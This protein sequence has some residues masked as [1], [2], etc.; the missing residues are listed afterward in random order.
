MSAKENAGSAKVLDD[1]MSKLS[2]SKEAADI[3]E[4]NL[5]LASFINGNIQDQEAPVR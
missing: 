5:A 4:A 1:L 3:K 2:I